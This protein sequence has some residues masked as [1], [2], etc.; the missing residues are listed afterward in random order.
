MST[1]LL[2]VINLIATMAIT[3]GGLVAFRSGMARTASEVQERVIH[4]LQSEI[5]TLKSRIDRL[6][7]ENQHLMTIQDIIIDSLKKRGIKI[8][9]EKSSVTI[10]DEA[11]KT[12]NVT[13]ITEVK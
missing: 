4:A 1:Q 12:T 3:V 8:T 13:R 11:A 6:D 10:E 2:T 7:R 9:I 5:E